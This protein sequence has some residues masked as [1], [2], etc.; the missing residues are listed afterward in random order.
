MNRIV[1]ITG[2]SSGIGKEMVEIYKKCG[3]N[4]FSLAR[5][6]PQNDHEIE[7]DVTNE[8]QVKLAIE[9]IGTKFGKI[10]ILIN[11]AGYGISGALELIPTEEAEKEFDVNML[12]AFIVN[13]YAIKFMKKGSVIVH[14]ASACA[15]FALPFRGLYCASKSALNMYS[16]SLRMEL[17]PFGIKVVS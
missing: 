10:D 13:K 2:G 12:G 7:V 9:Q 1:V 3:D 17:K 16:D 5:S 15:L 11:C 14:I 4:V 8:Q 6:T